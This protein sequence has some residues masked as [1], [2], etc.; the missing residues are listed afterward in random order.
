M[1]SLELDFTFAKKKKKKPRDPSH[2]FGDEAS[3]STSASGSSM[4]TDDYTYAFLLQRAIGK[5]NENNPALCGEPMKAKLKPLDVQRE[6]TKKT[7]V[8]NF[9]TLCKE[10]NRDKNH[11]LSFF[12]SELCADGSIDGNNRMIIKG[13][14]SPGAIS[15]IARKYIQQYVICGEC[16]GIDTFIDRDKSTRLFF[17]CCNTC[18][19]SQSIKPIQQGFRAKI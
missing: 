8:T 16:K 13:R 7:V 18:H 4:I 9:D 6:G 17:L 14:Y 11:V 3:A 10:I 2:V 1:D 12:M 5:I 15:S 19:A